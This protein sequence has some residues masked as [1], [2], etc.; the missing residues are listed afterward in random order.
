MTLSQHFVNITTKLGV[1]NMA[2]T[3]VRILRSNRF[4]LQG[5]I[6]EADAIASVRN[7]IINDQLCL[8]RGLLLNCLDNLEYTIERN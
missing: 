7:Q 3:I 6:P 1:T 5:H 4:H 8:N 2:W